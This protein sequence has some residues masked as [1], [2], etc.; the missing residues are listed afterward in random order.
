MKYL[1]MFDIGSV[2]EI[3]IILDNLKDYPEQV[4]F[5]DK[6]VFTQKI[7]CNFMVQNLTE[8]ID[9]SDTDYHFENLSGQIVV[10]INQSSDFRRV[11]RRFGIQIQNTRQCTKKS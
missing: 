3:K 6:K 1:T 10:D 11:C 5:Y 9:V 4:R 8:W 7:L 2:E